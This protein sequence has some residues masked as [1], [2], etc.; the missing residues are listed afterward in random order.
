MLSSAK[1]QNSASRPSRTPRSGRIGLRTTPSQ[2]ATLR[3]AAEVRNTSLTDFILE[4][5]CLAAEQTLIDQ[6]LFLISGRQAEEFL[7]LL[8]RPAEDHP[9]LLDLFARPPAWSRT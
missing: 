6:R 9:G 1:R 2:E 3:R 8:D 5:A 7:A 4:S